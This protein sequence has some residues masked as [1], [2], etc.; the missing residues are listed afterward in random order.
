MII[1]PYWFKNLSVSSA[2][3][4]GKIPTKI[5]PP[6]RGCIGIRLKTASTKF[7]TIIK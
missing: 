4:A 7:M 3:F 1:R 2:S 5:F 6:S